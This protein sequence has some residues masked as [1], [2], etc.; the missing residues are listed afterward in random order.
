[1]PIPLPNL[2]DRRWAD[3]VEDGRAQIPRYAPS[4]TD[5][6]IHDPGITLIEL[7]AWLAEMTDYRLNRVPARHKAKFLQL[8]G[9][10]QQTPSAA[11]VAL[12]FAPAAATALFILPA[13]CEFEGTDLNGQVLPFRTLQDIT[14]SAVQLK[15]VQVDAANGVLLDRTH[16]F[17]DG[18]AIQLLGPDPQP[19]A[20]VYLGYDTLTPGV[21]ISLGIRLQPPGNSSAERLRI[22]AEAAAEAE[23]CAP[24]G[25]RLR[26][27]PATPAAHVALPVHH[28]VRLVWE[29]FTAAGWIAIPDAVD[30]TRSFTLDGFAQFTVPAGV[31]ASVLGTVPTPLFYLR[32]RM[33]SGAFDAVPVLLDIA[34][35]AV[36]AEQAIPATQ[37]FPIK[38]GTVAMGGPPAPGDSTR[39]TLTMDDAGVI[40]ALAFGAGTGPALRVW[41]YTAAG[42]SAGSLTLEIVLT[43]TAGVLPDQQFVLGL[44]PIDAGSLAVYTHA[45]TTWQRW[46]E[47]PDF[48]ASTRTSF[49]FVLDAET[50]LLTFGNGERGQT[51]A[52]GTRIFTTYRRTGAAAGNLPARS[53]TRLRKSVVNDVLLSGLPLTTR[54]QL[55]SICTNRALAIG[56][57]DA[58]SLDHALGRAV[59]VLHAHERLLTLC[60]DQRSTTLDQI[61]HADV[62]N[63]LPPTNAV[64]LIDYE[65][66]ALSV[67]G[68]HVDRARAWS[69]L[70]PN[71][72]CLDAPGVVTV[73]IVPE[74]PL[75]QPAPSAGLIERVWRYLNRRRTLCTN[76]QVIGPQYVQ[77]TVTATVRVRT[78]A[79]AGKVAARTV[80]ALNAF[81]NPLTGGPA[82]LGWPFGRNVYRSEILQLIQDV[83]GVDH[84]LTLS[85]QTD[86]GSSQCGD[87]SLCPT[88][89]VRSGLHQI[90][91]S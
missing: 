51:P 2:D 86:A 15:A 71:Y 78:G 7:F 89:L 1:M 82:S 9:F 42:A 53:V 88:A 69:S 3:L 23:A 90:G 34:V 81:L 91:V 52:A 29:A 84:V 25:T 55:S 66:I 37:T 12:S 36:A 74:A 65:R 79:S 46:T 44:A 30:D 72:P 57:S 18:F 41:G 56:G 32:C 21:P 19:N 22:L 70:H 61:P 39:L 60:A 27:L 76:L 75:A 35:N 14:V 31:I 80:E 73:V 33:I 24:A 50:G 6:N 10:R 62:L 5:Q 85:M 20:A 4:W 87:I 59:E 49:D 48:L 54:A 67:P 40:Q 83:P 77:V 8:L 11:T 28:S 45:G 38:A 63:L 68:T 16:D 26:C 43:G 64:N 47:R 17:V 13:G 58:E